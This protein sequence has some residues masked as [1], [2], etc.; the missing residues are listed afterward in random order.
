[1][2]AYQQ[3]LSDAM[4]ELAGAPD[5]LVV[6]RHNLLLT[7]NSLMG[8]T[9]GISLTGRI[10]IMLVY[11]DEIPVALNDYLW[12]ARCNPGCIIRCVAHKSDYTCALQHLTT[13][14][15]VYRVG[16]LSEGFLLTDLATAADRERI[17]N[18]AALTIQRDYAFAFS[19]AREGRSTVL[20]EFSDL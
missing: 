9:I 7:A 16:G 13:A 5:V 6:Y 20:V 8:V 1:M 15:R 4:T 17:G 2:T 19:E 18:K 10:P 12:L 14:I 3:A 11:M